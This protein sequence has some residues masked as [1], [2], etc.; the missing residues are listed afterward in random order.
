M[1]P[2]ANSPQ[3]LGL[4]FPHMENKQMKRPLDR[5]PNMAW[6]IFMQ[7]FQLRTSERMW[8]LDLSREWRT[9][10]Q[11]SSGAYFTLKMV[12]YNENYL[13]YYY[14]YYPLLLFHHFPISTASCAYIFHS[15]FQQVEIRWL[16]TIVLNFISQLPENSDASLV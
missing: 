2:W 4:L 15:V 10:C 14:Y 5:A 16:V 3:L 1:W 6:S 11:L 8:G 13:T 12:K 7:K 9:I